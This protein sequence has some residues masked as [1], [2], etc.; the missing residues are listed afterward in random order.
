MTYKLY[1]TPGACSLAP[2]IALRALNLDFLLEVVDLR[3]KRTRAGEDYLAIQP[4]GYVP[5]LELPNGERLG[6]VSVI[7]QYLADQRP[8]LAFMP[9][10]GTFERYRAMEM[11]SFIATELHKSFGPFFANPMPEEGKQWARERIE[12][13][14]AYL[15]QRLGGG[16]YLF[17][18]NLTAPDAYLFTVLTWLPWIRMQLSTW[19]KLAAYEERVRANS[20][21]KA[22]LEAEAELMRGGPN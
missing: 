17:G 4:L 9:P 19:P 22:A 15:D 10:L 12:R 1:M 5:M 13:R 7:L 3:G 2:H 18:E 16:S 6:E 11:L 20:A 14:L 8:E 21:V